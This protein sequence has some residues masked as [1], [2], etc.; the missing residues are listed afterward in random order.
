MGSHPIA[1]INPSRSVSAF[2]CPYGAPFLTEPLLRRPW[3]CYP[4]IQ[5]LSQILSETT[6]S[7]ECISPL[8]CW[9]LRRILALRH[10]FV[11][12]DA[13]SPEAPTEI[14]LRTRSDSC[15]SQACCLGMQD[16]EYCNH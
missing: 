9:N 3:D 5:A 14:A 4:F 8:Q 7:Q 11:N 16:S 1:W 10:L 13:C 12:S 2:R 6:T 15:L